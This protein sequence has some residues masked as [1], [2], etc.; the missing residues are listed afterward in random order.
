[1]DLP[2]DHH[3]IP[4]CFFSNATPTSALYT[5]SLHDAL[6]IY[7]GPSVVLLDRPKGKARSQSHRRRHSS[8]K[9]GMGFDEL[10]RARRAAGDSG[11]PSLAEHDHDDRTVP[12]A[13]P[14]EM[15]ATEPDTK[16][17]RVRP[18][19]AGPAGDD[20]VVVAATAEQSTTQ[21]QAAAPPYPD[22]WPALD[23]A[24]SIQQAAEAAANAHA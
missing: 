7:G 6:P 12:T 3:S 18:E 20:G 24:D 13:A 1:P 4:I 21:M 5:L 11:V 16:P 10:E 19:P 23:P 2:V 22:D 15:V 8:T 9:L 17:L 14:P